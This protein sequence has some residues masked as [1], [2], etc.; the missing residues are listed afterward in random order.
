VRYTCIGLSFNISD[1]VFGGLSTLLTL[2][3]L[4]VT[5][6]PGS[7]VWVLLV[8]WVISFVSFLKIKKSNSN[9]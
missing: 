8:G 7:F 5:K 2:Y 1:G 9:S 4:D 6:N 3:L